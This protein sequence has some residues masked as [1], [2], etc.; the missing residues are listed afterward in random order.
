MD[1]AKYTP[2]IDRHCLDAVF[3]S[4]ARS[5]GQEMLVSQKGDIY[6]WA[7]QAKNSSAE[8]DYVALINGKIYPVEVKRGPSGKLKNLHLFLQTYRNCPE[9]L[10]FSTR[11]YATMAESKITFMPIYFV[12]SATAWKKESG[13]DLET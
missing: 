8:V 3:T 9:G 1:F 11:P 12:F 5:V 2:H 6:Y 13:F 10:V 4:I 7:R